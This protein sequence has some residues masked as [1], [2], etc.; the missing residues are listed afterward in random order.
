MIEKR[1]AQIVLE[2]IY[3]GD[4]LIIGIVRRQFVYI[5]LFKDHQ[6]LT[7]FHGY[8]S[9]QVRVS[10]CGFCKGSVDFR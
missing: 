5:D 8:T 9:L 4:F 6:V 10:V 1:V 3:Q 7:I 2:A